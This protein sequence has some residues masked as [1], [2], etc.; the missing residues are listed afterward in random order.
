M[1]DIH[2]HILP[3]IDDG[4][5]DIEESERI[6]ELASNLGCEALI[7]TPH[8]RH[9]SW[10]NAEPIQLELMLKR[11]QQ[12]VGEGLGLYLG[13]EIRVSEGFLRDL[14]AFEN[15]GLVALANS[16]YLLLEFERRQISVDPIATVERVRAA[17]WIPIVAHPELISAFTREPGLARALYEAGALHQITAM[18]VTGEFGLEPK[19]KAWTLLETG[20]AH[21]VASDCHGHRRRPPGLKNAFRKIKAVLGKD[22]ATRLTLDNP[23]AV[24]ENRLIDASES[25]VQGHAASADALRPGTRDSQTPDDRLRS[26]ELHD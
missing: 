20:L 18:S 5:P 12:R 24:V 26:G 10:W 4:A 3:G 22:Y 14:E 9:P 17:G 21:F 6:C 2:S 19:Q 15:S 23:R 8:Q 1:I 13:A 7:A 16:R 11:I 25:A